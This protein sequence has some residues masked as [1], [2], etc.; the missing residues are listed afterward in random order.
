MADRWWLYAGELFWASS[1]RSVKVH[2]MSASSGLWRFQLKTSEHDVTFRSD[3]NVGGTLEPD[4]SKSLPITAMQRDELRAAIV[5]AAPR[6]KFDTAEQYIFDRV[7]ADCFE[8]GNTS[9]RRLRFELI[10]KFRMDVPSAQAKVEGVAPRYVQIFGDSAYATPLGLLKSAQRSTVEIVVET[11]LRAYNDAYSA[12]P[13]IAFLNYDD[14]FGGNKTPDIPFLH[15]YRILDAFKLGANGSDKKWHPAADIEHL[16][17][18]GIKS[19]DQF[20]MYNHIHREVERPWP[21]AVERQTTWEEDRF[22]G[23]LPVA[24]DEE[25][26]S[27]AALA[28][29]VLVVSVVTNDTAIGPDAIPVVVPTR[30]ADFGLKYGPWEIGGLIGS[31][32]YGR[33]YECTHALTRRLVAIK[34]IDLVDD[35]SVARFEREAGSLGELSHPAIPQVFDASVLK[36][37]HIAYIVIERLY[38]ASLDRLVRDGWRASED[39]T[40]AVVR[41]VAS[42]LALAHERGIIHRDIKPANLFLEE[43]RNGGRRLML[44]DFGCAKLIGASRL[45]K[46]GAQIGTIAYR[47][48]ES[49]QDEV[50][51]GIDVWALG[52]TLYELT[53][54]IQPFLGDNEGQTLFRILQGEVPRL[55]EGRYPRLA[56]VIRKCLSRNLEERPADATALLE[57]LK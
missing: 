14:Y 46:T 18:E 49:F 9:L 23:L 56:H 1:D 20:W 40:L 16:V 27:A 39:E 5:R 22:G 38:G 24:K 45:T 8:K 36:E 41:T 31:G 7:A 29:S 25:G 17:V 37:E 26:P 10:A 33:V 52:V 21:L 12:N 15:A 11:T 57:L 4:S 2:L 55:D 43:T 42:P 44:L 48:P 50:S 3:M 51:T 32:A 6:S 35:D 53:T 28:P 47:S 30:D 13:E 54:G 19:L 34:I